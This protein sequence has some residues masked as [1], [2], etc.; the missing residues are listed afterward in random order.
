LHLAVK[1]F[2]FFFFFPGATARAVLLDGSKG[3]ARLGCS[4]S[5]VGFLGAGKTT[6]KR[7][8]GR[9]RGAVKVHGHDLD[10]STGPVWRMEKTAW[11]PY[12]ASA[13][14]CIIDVGHLSWNLAPQR[15]SGWPCRRRPPG[16]AASRGGDETT[17]KQRRSRVC[18]AIGG[19]HQ[20]QHPSPVPGTRQRVTHPCGSG[21]GPVQY[22]AVLCCAVLHQISCARWHSNTTHD[23]RHTERKST[24]TM[25]NPTRLH[26]P[27]H[28]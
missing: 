17:Q 10:V 1:R 21:S 5:T 15:V 13:W 28:P 23:T 4:R 9:G 24:S 14:P 6:E 8:W 16:E 11:G 27:T 7:R 25:I 20:G 2:I 3:N 12:N 19:L 22:S 26:T 18:R